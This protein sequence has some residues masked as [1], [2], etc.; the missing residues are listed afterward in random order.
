MKRVRITGTE[1]F[2]HTVN[3]GYGSKDIF[4]GNKNGK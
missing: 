3:R 1:A 2:N 4:A